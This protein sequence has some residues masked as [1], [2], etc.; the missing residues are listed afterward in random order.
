MS[1]RKKSG[2]ARVAGWC[3]PPNAFESAK[4]KVKLLA[5]Q[6]VETMAPLEMS[7]DELVDALFDP[8]ELRVLRRARPLTCESISG[9]HTYDLDHA[10]VNVVL[11][12]NGWDKI[13]CLP[14][15]HLNVQPEADRVYAHMMVAG[16]II[17]KFSIVDHVLQ[18]VQERTTPSTVRSVWPCF[19]SLV[20][21]AYHD[22]FDVA[23]RQAYGLEKLAPL[24]RDSMGTL[25]SAALL[26]APRPDADTTDYTLTYK[27]AEFEFAGVPVKPIGFNISFN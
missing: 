5:I 2:S 13:S 23:Q 24:L 25:A 22:V 20:G 26:P 18:A 11:R 9:Y 16:E 27:M 17:K 7:C 4:H 21:S 19:M 3:L 14:P 10:G 12:V 1:R 8:E 15:K 6:T